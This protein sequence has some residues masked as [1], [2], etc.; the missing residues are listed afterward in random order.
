MARRAAAK[1]PSV[2]EYLAFFAA[3]Q[4]PSGALINTILEHADIRQDLGDGMVLFGGP[5]EPDNRLRVLPGNSGAVG[6]AE[7]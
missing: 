3:P 5:T 4:P 7:R 6:M 2:D 1:R